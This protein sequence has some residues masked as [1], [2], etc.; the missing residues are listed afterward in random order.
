MT[1]TCPSRA[2][3]EKALEFANH[4]GQVDFQANSG[5]LDKFKKLH[6]IKE[7]VVSGEGGSVSDE[8]YDIW[9]NTVLKKIL[10]EFSPD[11]IFNMDKTGLFFKRLP[12]KILKDDD[13]RG[14][15]NSK[16]EDSCFGG[17]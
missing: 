11:N 1:K 13:C 3:L 10:E 17:R 9:K 5:W 6:C 12:N 14:G 15:R 8:D 7:K 4:F 16:R 2:L